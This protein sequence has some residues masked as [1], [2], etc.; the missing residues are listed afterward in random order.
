MEAIE[1]TAIYKQGS[2]TCSKEI[3]KKLELKTNTEVKVIIMRDLDTRKKA[4]AV[5]ARAKLKAIELA[6]DMAEEEAWAFYAKAAEQVY[7]EYKAVRKQ[8]DVQRKKS[9]SH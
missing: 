4:K 5:I 8:A 2:L 3:A 7:Q 1:Y 9:E 6:K